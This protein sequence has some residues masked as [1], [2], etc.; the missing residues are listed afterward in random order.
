MHDRFRMPGI[1][2][3]DMRCVLRAYLLAHGKS[4]K[5]I[6]MRAHGVLLNVN[7]KEHKCEPNEVTMYMRGGTE[8]DGALIFM[9]TKDGDITRCIEEVV[10]RDICTR[11]LKMLIPFA[12]GKS[13][14]LSEIEK[15]MQEQQETLK[16]MC[17]R[18]RAV[19]ETLCEVVKH[20]N[21]MNT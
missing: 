13:D 19:E 12:G 17:C 4:D 14:T 1:T 9:S 15:D 8:E 11:A 21:A 2:K 7:E 20:L 18:L 3:A 16:R 6:I 5:D 10:S